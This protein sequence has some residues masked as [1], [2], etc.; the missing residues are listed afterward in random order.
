MTVTFGSILVCILLIFILNVYLELILKFGLE[1][2]IKNVRYVYIGVILLT[3]RSIIPINFPYTITLPVRDILSKATL[4]TFYTPIGRFKL[5]HYILVVWIIGALF[6]S[7]RFIILRIRFNKMV[8]QA[9]L[10]SCPY[11]REIN[12]VLKEFN[13]HTMRIAILPASISPAISGLVK[14]IFIFPDVNFC[15]TDLHFI[16]QHELMHYKRHDLLL[17]T[18]M[19]FC[20]CIM[21]WNPFLYL[22]RQKFLL[23]LEI[24]NDISI[25]KD[26]H[27]TDYINYAMCLLNISKLLGTDF[28]QYNALPFIN[29]K[30]ELKQRVISLLKFTNKPNQLLIAFNNV[31]LLVLLILGFMCIPEAYS[32]PDSI[33]NETFSI[34]T[35]N[36]YIIQTQQGYKLYINDTYIG[37]VSAIS[38][39]LNNIPIYKEDRL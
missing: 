28:C 24:S 37:T 29:R 3:L 30:S 16:I 21:W 11:K 5:I 8:N 2:S 35:K 7:L 36:S 20:V 31:F 14:P 15:K 4:L 34:D 38:D 12:K 6:F 13:A 10:I 39:E 27:K 19:D 32:I 25:M 17:K 9:A 18:L 26:C 22:C 23:S 33:K 1:F